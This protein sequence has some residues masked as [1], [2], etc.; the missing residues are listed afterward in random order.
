[1]DKT[2]IFG[3]LKKQASGTYFDLGDDDGDLAS[4]SSFR[5][6]SSRSFAS[7]QDNKQASLS[8]DVFDSVIDD[9]RDVEA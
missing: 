7:D 2:G 6:P 3:D 8:F 4:E 9:A 1:M 5:L